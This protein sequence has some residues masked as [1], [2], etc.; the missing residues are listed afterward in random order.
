MIVSVLV[1]QQGFHETW[2]VFSV[3]CMRLSDCMAWGHLMD[4]H[5]NLIHTLNLLVC[6][7]HSLMMWYSTCIVWSWHVYT[8]SKLLQSE[9]INSPAIT[10]KSKS[11]IGHYMLCFNECVDESCNHFLENRVVMNTRRKKCPLQPL[12]A[13]HGENMCKWIILVGNSRFRMWNWQSKT[14]S[15]QSKWFL[16]FAVWEET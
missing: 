7:N 6:T 3:E 5:W 16:G 4:Y 12:V 11:S 8:K 13:T 2:H 9:V 15:W 1:L 14:S 10:C